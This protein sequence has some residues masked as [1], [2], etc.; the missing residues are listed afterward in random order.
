MRVESPARM[1]KPSSD[2]PE[3]RLGQTVL[4]K[5]TLESVLGTGGMAA[6]Y[7]ARHSI[8]RREAIKILHPEVAR[9]AE[10]RKRFDQEA[11]AANQLGH[12]G[13]VEIRDVDIT[14]DG[15]PF[16]VMELLEGETL[17]DVANR[18]DGLPLPDLLR[19]T[20]EVLDVL[21]VAHARGIVHRD[22]KL[23]NLFLTKGG[24][25]KVLDFGIARIASSHITRAGARLGTTAYMPPEQIRGE[26]VDGRADLFAVGA[27][28]FRIIAKRR[29]HEAKTE[30]DLIAK[31]AMNPAPLL[32]TVCEAPPNVCL[33]VDRALAFRVAERYPDARTMQLDVQAVRR[34]EAP[35]FA[36]GAAPATSGAAA[37][38]TRADVPHRR[39]IDSNAATV[40]P[41]KANVAVAIPP[42]APP[43]SRIGFEPT[44]I[45][46]NE[47]PSAPESVR[48]R[49]TPTVR[50]D[51]ATGFA[52]AATVMPSP[53]ELVGLE[54]TSASARSSDVGTV[55][56]RVVGSAMP[57]IPDGLPISARGSGTPSGGTRSVGA[58][59]AKTPMGTPSVALPSAP[60]PTRGT[61]SGGVA[62]VGSAGT[63][64]ASLGA[65]NTVGPISIARSY[66]PV[67][68]GAQTV[69]A[70][71]DQLP[72]PSPS[73][74]VPGASTPSAK[75]KARD[76]VAIIVVAVLVVV[77]LAAA[78][79]GLLLRE[80]EEPEP[81]K[82]PA[83]A[84]APAAVV[85]LQPAP[86]Q[87][88]PT[89]PGARRPA[90][91][92]TP[93]TKPPPAPQSTSPAPTSPAPTSPAPTSP[94]PPATSAPPPP[95][96]ATTPPPP[97]PSTSPATPPPRGRPGKGH[98]RGR[99]KDDD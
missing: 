87:P 30:V 92:P 50:G 89:T 44:G 80:D 29:V 74:G 75:G 54:P 97:A 33:V 17:G 94:G 37:G 55:P 22:I 78:G 20:D 68:V 79:I 99:G 93:T 69:H 40:A 52:S 32:A 9:D 11:R 41:P 64:P 70:Q 46:S 36:A 71:A 23:G 88:A 34:G 2:H 25:I 16:M 58:Q 62:S 4:G 85:P 31:M 86:A 72:L 5:W 90:P 84:T 73:W 7:L 77:F 83:S 48:V 27:T 18:H 67:D 81:R 57:T 1:A 61:P 51:E 56:S 47:A 12:P 60:H 21:V 35:P 26:A 45:S 76:R 38:A 3:A 91:A 82:T 42:A 49:V 96:P 59:S 13:A 66:T 28:M 15:C 65:P 63:P 43:P 8:G 95:P 98:G 19:Y 53:R 39:P 10:Q 6:V 14:E 24:K